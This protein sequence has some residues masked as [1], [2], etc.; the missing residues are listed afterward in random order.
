MKLG[1]SVHDH[2][3]RFEKLLA[4]LKNLDEDIKD[5]V[6]VIIMLHSLLEEYNHFVTTLIYGK[7][8]IIF[9][10]VCITLTNLEIR[11]ND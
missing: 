1:V 7:N 5:E 4:N 2:V 10:D 6:N 11:N 8:V 3:S 9:K